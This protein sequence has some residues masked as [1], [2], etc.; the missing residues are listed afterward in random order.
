MEVTTKTKTGEPIAT[1]KAHALIV[2]AGVETHKL[3][4]HKDGFGAWKVT[5]PES[6]ACVAH[7]RGQYKGAVVSSKGFTLKEARA[8]AQAQIDALIESIGS[9][10]FNAVLAGAAK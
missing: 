1:F 3:A 7:V 5:H 4:L 10:K 8:A 6:G 2:I 9:A